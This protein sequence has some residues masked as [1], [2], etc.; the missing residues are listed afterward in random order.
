MMLVLATLLPACLAAALGIIHVY[1][2]SQESNWRSLRETARALAMLMENTLDTQRLAMR[3]MA[4]APSFQEGNSALIREYVTRL[5]RARGV[6]FLV[7]DLQGRLI[8]T[9]ADK[10]AGDAGPWGGGF[11][12]GP[13]SEGDV[14]VSPLYYS[15]HL[16][17]LAFSLRVPVMKGTRM[18]YV[19][20]AEIPV[21][22]IQA[23]L[24][25]QKLPARWIGTVLDSNTVIVARSRESERFVGTN[26]T[27]PIR[28]KLQTQE[29]GTNLGRALSGEMVN[30][31]FARLPISGWAFVVSVPQAEW[32]EPGMRAALMTGL[33]L[34]LILGLG[35]VAVS[36]LSRRVVRPIEALRA[37][38]I[39]MGQGGNPALARSGVAE[40]DDV[41]SELQN[42]SRS[43]RGA[44]ARLQEKVAQAV[45]ET[46]RTQRA[47]LQAQKLEALGRL[48]GGIAHDFNNVLQTL[49]SGL[50]IALHTSEDARVKNLLASCE[51]A[52]QRAVELTRQLM[53][54]GRVQDAR[55]VNLDLRQHLESILPLLKG[56]LPV[57]VKLETRLEPVWPVTL[58]PLQLELALLNLTI[59]ARDAMPHGGCLTLTLENQHL[60]TA[61]D[62]LPPGEYVC[63]QLIDTGQGMSQEIAS[64]ALDPFFTT[65]EVGAGSGLGL[66]QAYGFSRQSGGTLV[67][68]SQA[69]RGTRVNILLPRSELVAVSPVPGTEQDEAEPAAGIRL[70]FVEDDELVRNVVVHALS[71]HG[72]A[73]T[74]ATN[75]DDALAHLRSATFDMV[76]SDIV[77]P[78]SMNGIALAE[79]VRREWPGTHMMLATG[80]SHDRSGLPGVRVLGKP[81]VVSELVSAL[82]SEIEASGS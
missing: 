21:R 22:E 52:V 30:A 28:N 58:D 53:A 24:E 70:L 80:Y 56:A 6:H 66:P 36:L 67:L 20:Q 38:A 47:L 11:R 75:A 29:E 62:G 4:E 51:R 17:G 41:A 37:A 35:L 23:L 43:I 13:P 12:A 19:L 39:E 27:G 49:T 61:P 1:Q 2:N 44:E 16:K 50:A 18:L 10:P 82:R 69:G 7:L 59:N 64:R 3:T 68:H 15:N 8:A 76:F 65:K 78:G 60:D 81:Y 55:L 45:A 40:L 9:S 25:Q 14:D 32:R 79:I 42:A 71:A 34:I 57:H 5:G 33:A 77:M 72:F 54:F 73:V 74:V 46:E 63:L 31:Y 26:V 48:T